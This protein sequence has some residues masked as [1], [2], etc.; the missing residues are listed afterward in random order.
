MRGGGGMEGVRAI[1]GSGCGTDEAPR[2][3]TVIG[4]LIHGLHVYHMD[5]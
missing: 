3:I 2:L 1:S 4:P 5:H